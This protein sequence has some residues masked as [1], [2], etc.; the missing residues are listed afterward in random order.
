[1]NL[2]RSFTE[3]NTDIGMTYDEYMNKLILLNIL[4]TEDKGEISNKNNQGIIINPDKFEI[5]IYKKNSKQ[6]K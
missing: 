6:M 3:E 4:H 2:Y 5:I 1:M